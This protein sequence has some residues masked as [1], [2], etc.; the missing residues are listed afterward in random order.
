MKKHVD[1][2]FKIEFILDDSELLDQN[3]INPVT[4]KIIEK[5]D[6]DIS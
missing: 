1:K 5:F 4:K 3:E 2:L 6:A